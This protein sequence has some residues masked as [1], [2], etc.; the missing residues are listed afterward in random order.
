[1]HKRNT[2]R[3]VE[4][5]W[6]MLDLFASL[7]ACSFDLTQTDL[8]GYKCDYRAAQTIEALRGWMPSLLAVAI[9]RRQNLIVR[10]RRGRAELVQLDDVRGAMLERLR[11]TAFL[12]LTTSHGN[13]Q[14]CYH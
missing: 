1:M 5:A 2:G 14:A 8:D 4:E 6:R 12:I 3:G 11:Q 13:H 7:G 10:P 9:E